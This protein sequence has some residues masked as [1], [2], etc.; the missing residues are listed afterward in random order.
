MILI[1]N[2][3]ELALRTF[4]TLPTR[5]TNFSTPPNLSRDS[6]FPRLLTALEE[7]APHAAGAVS[8]G[9]I[10][11]FHRLRN[12]LYHHGSGLTVERLQAESYAEIA[13]V[14][15]KALFDS[16]PSPRRV[17]AQLPSQR[18]RF[19]KAWADLEFLLA[20]AGLPQH[21]A[22]DDPDGV[23][24]T[25]E[26]LL[27]QEDVRTLLALRNLKIAWTRGDVADENSI[28][29]EAVEDLRAICERVHSPPD[30][31]SN[32]DLQGKLARAWGRFTRT[33]EEKGASRHLFKIASPE[34]VFR[35]FGQSLPSEIITRLIETERTLQRIRLGRV[36]P[37]EV[38]D[39]DVIETVWA[40]TQAIGELAPFETIPKIECIRR[41]EE[42]LAEVSPLEP[43]TRFEHIKVLDFLAS[44]KEDVAG[45][46]YVLRNA[47]R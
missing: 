42:A 4:L 7:Y 3:V 13:R 26:G 5:I 34:D 39:R 30:P 14:L 28:S 21:A 18:A 33:L 47:S 9:E 36:T 40:A 16:D 41:P 20:V 17:E 25:L 10:E 38:V 35:I 45:Y 29:E 2:S 8:L 22:F 6:T 1:D 23:A 12:Q 19:F 27:N 11:W 44:F 32:A 46:E 31:G 15:M 24:T 43:Q 37:R